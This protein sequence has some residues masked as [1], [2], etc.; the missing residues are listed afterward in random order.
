MNNTF[1]M[2]SP[3]LQHHGILGMKWGIRKGRYA[4]SYAK[5]VKK[6]KKLD[7]DANEFERKSKHRKYQAAKLRNKAYRT[8]NANRRE[9]I[10]SKAASWEARGAKLEYSA[11]RYRNKG[12]KFYKKMERAFEG[13]D[14]KSLNKEDVEYGKRY[15]NAIL[16]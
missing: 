8:R 10:L 1:S 15:L 14:T 11:E 7:R 3:E 16:S 4:E 2:D 6:L 5:G 12:K 13:V 9:R